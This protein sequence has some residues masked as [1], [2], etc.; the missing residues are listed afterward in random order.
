MTIR[1]V[2]C[3][4]TWG[5][6]PIK[7]KIGNPMCIFTNGD[8]QIFCN[9]INKSRKEMNILNENISILHSNNSCTFQLS[10]LK[11][12]VG[13]GEIK[14]VCEKYAITISTTSWS[15]DHS[16]FDSGLSYVSLRLFAACSYAPPNTNVV[17]DN[18][19]FGLDSSN[20]QFHFLHC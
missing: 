15:L 2:F 6:I 8:T 20:R 4:L 5:C 18:I 9:M 13:G 17:H 19:S 3:F 12:K 14:L 11:K 1:T 10:I 16:V 7:T